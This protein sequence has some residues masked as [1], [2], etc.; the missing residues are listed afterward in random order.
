MKFLITLSFCLLSF[1]TLFAQGENNVW[2]LGDRF[3]LDFNGG[4]D[5]PKHF[6]NA[7]EGREGLAAICDKEGKLLFYSNGQFVWDKNHNVMPNSIGLLG[8]CENSSSHGTTIFPFIDDSN[9]YY[10]FTTDALE[11]VYNQMYLRYSVIDMSLNGGLGDIDNSRKNIILDSFISESILI[12]KGDDCF[13]WLLAHKFDTTIIDAFKIDNFGINTIPVVS[14]SGIMSK[15]AVLRQ[16]QYA[17]ANMR[18]SPDGNYIA[19]L[20]ISRP[21]NNVEIHNFDKLTGIVSNAF[22]LSDKLNRSF[23]FS[24]N[25]RF[26]Y[27]SQNDGL[28]QYDLSNVSDTAAVK[29]SNYNLYKTNVRDYISFDDFRIG[30]DKKLYVLTRN[31]D[32]NYS[33]TRLPF[34]NKLGSECIVEQNVILLPTFFYEF[35]TTV[36]VPNRIDTLEQFYDSTN[37]FSANME[38]SA[39]RFGQDR[40]WSTGETT[41]NIIVSNT[42]T[43]WVT[44]TVDA[45]RVNIDTFRVH[46]PKIFTNFKDTTICNQ[47]TLTLDASTDG[48]LYKWQDE[49]SAATFTTHKSGKYWVNVIT[50]ECNVT[51][52][53][54]V[55]DGDFSLDLGADKT[56]CVDE[57][58][59]LTSGIVAEAFLWQDASTAPTFD[60]KTSGTY[61]LRASR[62]HCFASDTIIVNKIV[63]QNCLSIPNAFSPNNDNKND[64]FQAVFNCSVIQFHLSIYN[65]YGALVFETN[66]PN[67]RWNGHYNGEPLNFGVYYYLVKARFDY[68]YAKEEI[69]K[70]NLT[71]IR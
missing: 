42:S 1:I 24:P 28:Y 20:S 8:N 18:C 68:P 43:V 14:N 6:L 47:Q 49:S 55:N 5:V 30:P 52:T 56:L 57:P 40:L 54:I 45:C 26:L 35:G 53:L 41:P 59:T 17:G 7:A 13:F 71:L 60:V 58:L 15:D 48:A 39:S 44:T 63:C 10:I 22:I 65:R 51:D 29:N 66:Q 31:Y 64:Y 38:L 32:G 61:W 16:Y 3:G 69:I 21:L 62:G 23:G 12:T 37:C 2:L 36:S 25:G 11:C 19:T 34:P 67:F 50:D 27:T 33:I 46:L 9:K 70:G 4:V